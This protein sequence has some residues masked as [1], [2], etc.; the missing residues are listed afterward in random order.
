MGSAE[1]DK[2]GRLRRVVVT[3]TGGTSEEVQE[4][5]DR[6]F[7]STMNAARRK[8][9]W[10]S[11]SFYLA[12]T[13]IL[14]I[15]LLAIARLAPVWT[16]PVVIAGAVLLMSVVGAFQL[17]QD[18]ALS[19][20]GFLTLMI[21]ALGKVPK[22]IRTGK[23]DGA[24]SAD[25]VPEATERDQPDPSAADRYIVAGRPG[26]ITEVASPPG[27]WFRFRR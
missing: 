4:A 12:A 26:P 10:V 21:A 20:Y 14:L 2:K 22:L 7:R 19:E 1:F 24:T 5:Y 11:G 15:V 25:T 16:V 13:L 27:R 6:A 18:D 23:P 3:V 8:S 9:P 17:R